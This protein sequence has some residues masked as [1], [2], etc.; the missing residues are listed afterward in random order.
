MMRSRVARPFAVRFW[1][2]KSIFDGGGC[3]LMSPNI[4]RLAS[5]TALVT[6]STGGLGAAFA[7]ALAEQGAFVVVT[8]RDKARGRAVLERIA[9]TGGAAAVVAAGPGHGAPA[10]GGR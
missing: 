2:C 3:G 9:S 8:G 5:H 10:G 7:T 4:T 6:G 1:T